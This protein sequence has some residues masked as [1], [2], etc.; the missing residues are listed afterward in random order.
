MVVCVCV[1]VEGGQALCAGN[2][3]PPGGKSR[4]GIPGSKGASDGLQPKG[5]VPNRC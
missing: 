2:R 5:L 1:C 3:A 4:E